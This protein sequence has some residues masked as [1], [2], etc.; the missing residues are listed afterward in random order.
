MKRWISGLAIIILGLSW[1]FFSQGNQPLHDALSNE[2][3]VASLTKLLN[4]EPQLQ[5]KKIATEWVTYNGKYIHFSYPKA[6]TRYQIAS[7]SAQIVASFQ[8]NMVDHEGTISIQVIKMPDIQTLEEYPSVSLRMNQKNIYK[9]NSLK[10]QSSTGIA[11][12]KTIDLAEKSCFFYT[13]GMIYTLAVSGN[14]IADIEPIYNRI[15]LS[16]S[17]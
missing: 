5:D 4:R 6:I 14:S 8:G 16:L 12:T 10:V 7:P 11:F 9:Q 3:K 17:F 15:L 13:N 2:K 1:Y